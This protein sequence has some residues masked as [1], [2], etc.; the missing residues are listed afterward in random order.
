MNLDFISSKDPKAPSIAALSSAE[1][2]FVFE[3]A[4]STLQK[5]LW[6]QCP[7]ALFLTFVC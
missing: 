5:K 6:F 3:G 1:G 7:P 2:P 4:L